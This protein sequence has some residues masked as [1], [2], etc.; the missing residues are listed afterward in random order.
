MKTKKWQRTTLA[1]L[2]LGAALGISAGAVNAYF[3]SGEGTRNTFT[4]GQVK[5]SLNELSWKPQDGK[6]LVARETVKKDPRITNT[7][8]NDA[9]VFM[10]VQV[11]VRTVTMYTDTGR[12]E[13]YPET[14]E[15]FELKKKTG[16]GYE[17]L[18]SENSGNW[19]ELTERTTP[20]TEDK[21]FTTYVYA[22]KVPLK[23]GETTEAL[24]DAV[25][26]KNVI[27]GYSEISHISTKD[28]Y[29]VIVN[30]YAIQA[31]DVY[32][33]DGTDVT[34]GDV[35]EA[36]LLRMYDV[37][38]NQNGTSTGSMNLFTDP[39]TKY[40]DGNML[41]P[42]IPKKT[43]YKSDGYWY[44]ESGNKYAPGTAIPV[45]DEIRKNGFNIHVNWEPI[46]YT[47]HFD[48]NGGSG[49]MQDMELSYDEAKNLTANAF[50]NTT[51][52]VGWS[53]S[54]TG[55]INFRDTAAVRNLT[56]TDGDT[57]NLYA[58]WKS[59]K[60]Q[61]VFDTNGGYFG[62]DPSQTSN[63]ISYI[64]KNINKGTFIA[65][66]NNQDTIFCSWNTAKD[67]SG[68]EVTFTDS[69]IPKTDI[70]KNTT[71][72]ALYAPQLLEG[73][74]DGA[75]TKKIKNIANNGE[76]Y[77]GYADITAIQHSELP[78]DTDHM[79]D[80]NIISTSDSI[81]PIYM[82]K[83]GN[84]LKW[85][86][87]ANKIM[88]GQNLSSIFEHYDNLSD[89]SGLADWNTS[90]VTDLSSLFQ[91]CYSLTDLD[92]LQTWNTSRVTDMHY[93]LNSCYQLKSLKGLENWNT[94]NV[95]NMYYM[96][97][98]CTNLSDIQA[99]ANW[100]M[101]NIKD[102]SYFFAYNYSLSDL[103]P[104]SNW[105]VSNVTNMSAMFHACWS[106]TTLNGLE[107]WDTSNVID[108]SSMF[109]YCKNSSNTYGSKD[110]IIDISALKNWNVSKVEDMRDMFYTSGIPD[111]SP[112]NDWD[113]NNVESFS[114]MF[115][116][117]QSH[118]IFSKRA[119]T[120]NDYK[121]AQG[122]IEFIGGTFTPAA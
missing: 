117:C 10:T 85:W 54:S 97:N 43:G 56:E 89:L 5:I 18:S 22:Y 31:S 98:Y 26:L 58:L 15:L 81:T 88:A 24:F 92:G 39:S 30:G 71:V 110:G 3:T 68:T 115:A 77:T 100:N 34:L 84:T 120:W 28:E 80:E 38:I 50:T 27:E 73:G 83:D 32:G 47:V 44:D 57:I 72:Y 96:L 17:T 62:D 48:A 36:E 12:K 16:T 69:G 114:S 55:S 106:L 79:K 29:P 11:P 91:G 107:N 1:A 52:F 113:I 6:N 112:I 118:P 64:G 104:L 9:Y 67:G 21:S 37:Y 94:S 82:W 78:P 102:M 121:D 33:A 93:M 65:S 111:A 103:R 101:V 51:K 53:L 49:T 90:H 2:L 60:Y 35:S 42:E 66:T 41:V 95:T 70:S 122:N 75:L 13:D 4:T 7:G 23:K 74:Y 116:N 19:V 108:M 87:K 105:N 86:S 59:N 14:T 20:G 45:T 63:S 40:Q 61:I 46:K 99:L 76:G 25:R 8:S 119:G 109:E